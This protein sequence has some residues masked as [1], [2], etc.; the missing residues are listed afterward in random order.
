[1]NL[2]KKMA[3]KGSY[4]TE[5]LEFA[6]HMKEEFQQFTKVAREIHARTGINLFPFLDSIE[7]PVQEEPV[8]PKL[9]IHILE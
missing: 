2:F 1:M 9:G 4:P 8:D 3:E 7:V 5:K 6:P